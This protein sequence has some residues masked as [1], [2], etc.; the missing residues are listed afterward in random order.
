MNA[1]NICLFVSKPKSN[2][3]V[4]LNNNTLELRLLEVILKSPLVYVAA[5]L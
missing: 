5:K 4:N 3:F 2:G 1:E